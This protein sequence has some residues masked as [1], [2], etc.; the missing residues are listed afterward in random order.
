MADTRQWTIEQL[1][2][3]LGLMEVGKYVQAHMALSNL[4]HTIKGDQDDD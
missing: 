2:P 4:L 3:I 1:L